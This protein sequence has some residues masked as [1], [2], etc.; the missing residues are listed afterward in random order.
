MEENWSDH[1]IKMKVDKNKAIQL[2]LNLIQNAY[3]A[4]ADGGCLTL[5]EYYNDKYV[6][7]DVQDTGK[8]MSE[9]VLNKIFDP[10]YT[11]KDPGEGTGLG[12][13]IC[14][15]IAQEM[16]ADILC[17]SKSDIGTKFT[18]RFLKKDCVVT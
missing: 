8:G 11:T 13:S 17:E 12:L 5:K 7:F 2:F 1:T 4:M 3:H 9:S 15:T 14:H 10:F 18:L 6:Y 16:R